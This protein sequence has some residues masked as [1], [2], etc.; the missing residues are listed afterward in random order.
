[1]VTSDRIPS[2][3]RTNQHQVT[4]NGGQAAQKL[5]NPAKSW[6]C[7]HSDSVSLA[8]KI[9]S[10]AFIAVTKTMFTNSISWL[11]H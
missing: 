1:M 11:V 6:M 7:G 8:N 2:K 9:D 10:C 4:L 3:W 5:D